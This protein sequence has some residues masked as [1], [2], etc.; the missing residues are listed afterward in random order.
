MITKTVSPSKAS[1]KERLIVWRKQKVVERIEKPS[2]PKRAHS[3]GYKAK[4]GFVVA[5]VR[6]GK[7]KRK[8]PKPTGGRVPKKAGRFFSTGKSKQLMAEEKVAG[9]FPNLEVLNSYYAGEDGQHKWYEVIM[10]DTNHPSVRKS[11]ETRWLT[12]KKH[13]RRVYRGKTSAGRKSRGLRKK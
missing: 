6:I 4:Q 5:R 8:R 11:E 2:N 1:L 13:T 12:N 7:G 10:A 3:L 9:K